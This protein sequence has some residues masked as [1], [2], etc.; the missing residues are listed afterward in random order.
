[1]ARCRLISGCCSLQSTAAI[2]LGL[3]TISTLRAGEPA[4]DDTEFFEKKIRPVLIEHCY[5]C[6]S[7]KAEKLK[8]K[9]LLDSKE[10]ARKGGESGPA[11]VPGDPD[12]SL[13]VQALRYENFEMP[14]K[15]KLP[16]AVISDFEQWIKHGAV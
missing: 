4:A 7:S 8:G 9:L 2:A 15:G 12:A 6:H 16:P 3:L 14:P 5:Q 11:I 13:V 1:M 10:A